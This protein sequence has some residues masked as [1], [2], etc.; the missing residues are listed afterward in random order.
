MPRAPRSQ[1]TMSEASPPD[2]RPTSEDCTPTPLRAAIVGA[3]A[4]GGWVGARLARA[5]GCRL[6]VWARGAT[7]EA[8]ER[9]GWQMTDP[10]GTRWAARPAS[11]GS[12]EELGAQD[13]VI[14]SVKTTALGEVADGTA[15]LMGPQ[16]AVLSLVNGVPWWF[17]PSL[18]ALAAA[19]PRSVD[20]QGR[21]LARWPLER[22]IGGVVHASASCPAPGHVVH[23]GGL[24]LVIG[25]PLH[26]SPVPA[27]HD[28]IATLLREAGLELTVSP[29]I[30]Q[31]LW[32][33][34]WGNLTM[35]PVSALTRATADR[36]LD[37]PQVRAFCSAA[38]REA[39]AAGERIGCPID[40]DPEAR[41]AVTRKLG[42]F[43]TSMLQDVEAGRPLELD[44]IV[45]AVREIAA[46]VGVATPT[47][48]ALH[49]LARLLD[50]NRRR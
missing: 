13:L 4:I 31:D 41:H 42:A 24:G 34:L 23:R 11:V 27:V 21:L 28:R 50:E 14:L 44:A 29:F 16:T 6:S 12:P 9:D 17:G 43:R 45:H 18:P 22:V 26:R 48:D 47:I 40:Q 8:L 2:S 36:I 30:Q 5:G 20:P 25:D 1:Q 35:N 10:D 19:P 39:A 33:K 7:R 32:Y 37:D 38:M 46:Q 3:G 49:G 15:A